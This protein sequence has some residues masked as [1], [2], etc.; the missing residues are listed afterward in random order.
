[1]SQGSKQLGMPFVRFVRGVALMVG[2]VSLHGIGVAQ[3]AGHS[4]YAGHQTRDITTLSA[5]DQSA[6]RE[7]QGWGLARP[8]ELNGVP[9]PL[10]LLEL[11]DA[12]KLSDSQRQ[13]IQALYDSMKQ[14]AIKLG[15]QYID[16]ERALDAYFKAGSLSD[17]RL[18]QLVH[19]SADALAKLRFLHLSFHHKTLEIVTPEQVR[20][21]NVLRGY[22]VDSTPPGAAGQQ[23]D[24]CAN[25]PP[26]HDPVMFRKHM[27]CPP[28]P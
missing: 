6:L 9:G 15:E 28:K 4:P 5:D 1:M 26:G 2:L 11:A 7:G 16:A 10:H 24:R 8:A 19:N 18:E 21:Y 23:T 3:H 22:A 12:I 17:A 13:A 27:G 25:V 14:Q 20:Q